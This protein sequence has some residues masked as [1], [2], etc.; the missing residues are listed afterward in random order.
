MSQTKFYGL[1][2]ER[3]KCILLQGMMWRMSITMY[4]KH[5]TNSKTNIFLFKFFVYLPPTECE[6]YIGQDC[7]VSC[8]LPA[9]R[10]APDLRIYS[11]K[12]V[13]SYSGQVHTSFRFVPSVIEIIHINQW[14]KSPWLL[15]FKSKRC[16]QNVKENKMKNFD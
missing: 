10:T 4:F 5:F 2:Y 12:M 14:Y 8:W 3:E 9:L 6:L 13:M 7:L 1:I 11:V 16:P 15:F